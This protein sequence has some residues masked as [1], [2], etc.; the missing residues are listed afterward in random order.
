[1]ALRSALLWTNR[2]FWFDE[3]ASIAVAQHPLSQGIKICALDTHPPLYFV[4][5]RLSA[6]LF[7][8][9]EWAFRLPSLAAGILLLV[10]VAL[11]AN[12]LFGKKVALL[13]AYFVAISPYFIHLSY[14][15]RNHGLPILFYA[16]GSF[17]FFKM[18]EGSDRKRWQWSYALTACA[19]LYTVHFAWFWL[20]GILGL[21]FF[22][23]RNEENAKKAL[24]I[25][26]L[27]LCLGIP[28]LCLLA[29]NVLHRDEIRGYNLAS[30]HKI[31]IAAKEIVFVYWNILVGSRFYMHWSSSIF[32]AMRSSVF[33][34]LSLTL[35]LLASVSIVYEFSMIFK[36]QK[37]LFYF[38]IFI[39]FVP[40]FL[41]SLINTNRL[42]AR[43]FSFAALFLILIFSK[44]LIDSHSKK[45]RIALIVLTTL[46][47][48]NGFVYLA[49]THVDPMHR[50]DYQE[51]TRYVLTHAKKN[52]LVFISS[53]V[54]NYYSKKLGIASQAVLT[55]DLGAWT[56]SKASHIERIWI[57]GGTPLT[58]CFFKELA[59]RMEALG[60]VPELKFIDFGGE[61]NNT[62]LNVFK[63]QA[64][65]KK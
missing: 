61:D 20:T 49:Q 34:W 4:L 52:D 16:A 64:F 22:L 14:E 47:S 9:K 51:M 41:V 42:D 63:N 12:R 37:S 38:L 21:H 8:F 6:V 43:Y 13:S 39:C 19:A 48:L 7:E 18:I 54:V 17:L 44:S 25:Q 36:K 59:D 23:S 53:P 31:A 65:S 58:S 32:S 30:L 62:G 28:E 46:V 10:F 26:A 60:F 35:F 3:W 33:F 40:V 45:S 5:L 57:T 50:D 15:I 29:Y 55:E 56:R 27:V 1:M 11:L 2:S 24:K